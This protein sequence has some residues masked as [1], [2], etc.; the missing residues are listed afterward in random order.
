MLGL[1]LDSTSFPRP[2]WIFDNKYSLQLDGI[3]DA[4]KIRRSAD[5]LADGSVASGNAFTAVLWVGDAEA[6]WGQSST[7]NRLMGNTDGSGW[8]MSHG[9]KRITVNMKVQDPS[10]PTLYENM[11]ISTHYNRLAWGIGSTSDPGYS[12]G[13]G[14]W[15][16]LVVTFDGQASGGAELK[17]YIG[18]GVNDSDPTTH[19]NGIHLIGTRNATNSGTYLS[20]GAKAWSD[21]VDFGIGCVFVNYANTPAY[22]SSVTVDN[23]AYFNQCLTQNELVTI[24][25]SGEGINMLEGY[26]HSSGDPYTTGMVSN[27]KCHLRLEGGSGGAGTTLTDVSG[28]GN[29][30]EIVG[31]PDWTN[32]VPAAI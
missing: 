29:S 22:H 31:S 27:L 26:N 21:D 7:E 6:E 4:I 24:Y 8:D 16:M 15:T 28:N 17:L 13:D 20:Y 1:G 18:G 30:G 12:T 3:T 14:G 5:M 19:D 25:N 23:F 9:N 11:V 2:L 32:N 10:D